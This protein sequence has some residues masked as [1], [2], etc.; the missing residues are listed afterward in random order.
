MDVATQWE[1]DQ[2]S[3]EV[4]EHLTEIHTRTVRMGALKRAR[5]ML[6]VGYSVGE[7][8]AFLAAHARLPSATL[9][10]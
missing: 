8:R 4:A 9:A 3:A 1:I 7:V 10:G 5:T 6:A 2:L